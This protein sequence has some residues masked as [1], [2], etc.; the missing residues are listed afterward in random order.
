MKQ[1]IEKFFL[2]A[3]SKITLVVLVFVY[4][5]LIGPTAI[6]LKI[7]RHKRLRNAGD[8]STWVDVPPSEEGAEAYLRQF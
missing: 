3:H 8:G 5:S 6:Y 1:K 7:L 4:F 2:A